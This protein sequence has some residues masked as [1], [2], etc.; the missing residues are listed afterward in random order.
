MRQAG[1]VT[2]ADVR[3]DEGVVEFLTYSDMR[4]ALEKLHGMEIYGKRIRLL[5][6][7]VAQARRRRSD[8]RSRS[9]SYLESLH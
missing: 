8:S 9:R 7:R 2:Y 3:G 1:E 4:R 6:E 5:E